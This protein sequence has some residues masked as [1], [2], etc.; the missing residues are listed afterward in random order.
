MRESTNVS[1][2]LVPM[3][4]LGQLGRKSRTS[5]LITWAISRIGKGRK[6]HT[7][8]VLMA[9]LP[10]LFTGCG[11]CTAADGTG[12][13]GELFSKG[14]KY[15]QEEN[16][17]KAF[18]YFEKSA[19]LGYAE[20]VN[21]LGF[22]YEHGVG[23]IYDTDRAKGFYLK[24]ERL[25]S[26]TAMLNLALMYSN[27]DERDIGKC[28]KYIEKAGNAI[29]PDGS[30]I[31]GLVSSV[32]T[33]D[34]SKTNISNIKAFSMLSGIKT[35]RLSECKKLSDIIP[36]YG[37]NTLT[38]LSLVGCEA[39]VDFRALSGLK[40]LE[41]LD[42]SETRI[43]KGKP[44]ESLKLIKDLNISFTKLPKTGFLRGLLNIERLYI[45]GLPFDVEFL[46]GMKQLT[47]LEAFECNIEN[48]R[49][50]RRMDQL[51]TLYLSRSLLDD[52][53]HFSFALDID[54]L[55]Y[56]ELENLTVT[57]G[58][59]SYRLKGA[60]FIRSLRGLKEK[61]PKCQI[62]ADVTDD[63]TLYKYLRHPQ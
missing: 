62:V 55:E 59:G 8:A 18:Q 28:V 41:V 50:F 1:A 56:V 7:L 12:Q 58:K 19:N 17:A 24:A 63:M 45:S 32:K 11:N 57:Q 38:E 54:K 29:K 22:M 14:I 21:N 37:L 13:A 27:G 4:E 23:R 3:G 34:L 51:E 48:Y 25:G 16:H 33:L 30:N 5:G 6:L 9:F 61:K 53:S 31:G 15:F 26:P 20:A 52:G 39:I 2:F 47:L 60:F 49:S 44:L 42:V 36:L 35:L 40:N 43:D 46:L 10:S